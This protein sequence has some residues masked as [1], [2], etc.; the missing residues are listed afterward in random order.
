M[1]VSVIWTVDIGQGSSLVVRLTRVRGA[2][3]SKTCLAI[4]FH[5]IFVFIPPFLIHKLQT[6]SKYVSNNDICWC[7]K[8]K[9]VFHVT[10]PGLLCHDLL[11]ETYINGMR[12]SNFQVVIFGKFN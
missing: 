4:Y 1:V 3:G 2:S 6:L 8:D 7:S 12:I 11:S 10:D 5:C 9:N